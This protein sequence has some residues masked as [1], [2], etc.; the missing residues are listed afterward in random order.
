MVIT[1]LRFTRLWLSF[2]IALI[3]K[4]IL[5]N[6]IEEI[7]GTRGV[8]AASGFVGCV[9]FMI[10]LVI[11]IYSVVENLIRLRSGDDRFS[12]AEKIRSLT[13]NSRFPDA[14]TEHEAAEPLIPSSLRSTIPKGFIFGMDQRERTYAV[15][16]TERDGHIGVIGRPGSG[17]SR[18]VAMPTIKSWEDPIFAIDLKGEL[19]KASMSNRSNTL[20]CFSPKDPDAYGYDPFYFVDIA[21]HAYTAIEQIANS[22]LPYPPEVKDDFWIKAP[23][24]ILTGELLY[25]YKR[26]YT[27]IEAMQAIQ[28]YGQEDVIQEIYSKGDAEERYCI[29][30]FKDSGKDNET[31]RGIVMQLGANIGSFATDPAIID[32]FSRATIITPELL[33]QGKDIY[34]II[35]ED[36]LETWKPM[37]NLILAQ[38]LKAF[39]GREEYPDKKILFL[40]DEFFR[41]G[42]IDGIEN[43]LATLRSRGIT[44]ALF[45]QSLAQLDKLYGTT[46]RKL[47]L[48]NLG[49]IEILSIQEAETQRYFSDMIGTYTMVTP[50]FSQHYLRYDFGSDSHGISLQTRDKHILKPEDLATLGEEAVVVGEEGYFKVKKLI[51][52]L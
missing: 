26:G 33:E 6:S 3:V 21:D 44:I 25:L 16:P 41:L 5:N 10:I 1:I 45:F 4:A 31:L 18:Y 43:A 11:T 15:K 29:S 22:L 24:R 36:Q 52:P 37:L 30:Y 32:A 40:I 19:S 2:P 8:D 38:F 34:L 46:G 42:R 14:R 20:C 9:T 23:R 50:S 27:F 49:F 12:I 51:H 7:A 48:D 47:I 17:K 39:E 35:P 13:Q 28:S